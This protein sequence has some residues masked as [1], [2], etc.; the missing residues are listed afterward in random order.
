MTLAHAADSLPKSNSRFNQT[1][2]QLDSF[3]MVDAQNG[4]GRS[5]NGRQAQHNGAAPFEM[6]C[7]GLS[8]WMKERHNPA[9]R[10]IYPS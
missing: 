7:P 6:P 2:P 3:W 10:A 5:A 4:D 8:T 9:R 1:L